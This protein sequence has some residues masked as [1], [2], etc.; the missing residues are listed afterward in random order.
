[1]IRLVLF[2]S[3]LAC[4]FSCDTALADE[5]SSKEN[6]EKTLASTS[7]A[8]E[9][10]TSITFEDIFVKPYGPKGLEYTAKLRSL[11][12]KRVQIEGYLISYK[13]IH[14]VGHLL[15][16]NELVHGG[17][18][19][20]PA[21]VQITPAEYAECD[22]LP[23]C[24]IFL[25]ES[26][27]INSPERAPLFGSISGTLELGPGKEADGRTSWLRLVV[28]TVEPKPTPARQAAMAG[29]TTPKPN[30]EALP[31]KRARRISPQGGLT[32]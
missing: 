12:G 14:T 10:A 18:I 20:T 32:R 22:D 30:I 11:E 19:L 9:P 25:R 23:A 6:T 29:A 24:A 7:E 15:K 13:V 2:S 17:C 26:T 27:R 3:L 28:D 1:M 31:M 21:P 4:C 16:F 8:N 5:A